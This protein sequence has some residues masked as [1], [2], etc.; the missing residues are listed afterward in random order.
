[1]SDHYLDHYHKTYIPFLSSY[2]KFISKIWKA[3]RSLNVR[4][5]IKLFREFSDDYIDFN[6]W[7][8]NSIN[9]AFY[10]K[11]SKSDNKTRKS[12]MNDWMNGLS[13]KVIRVVDKN[14]SNVMTDQETRS[15]V[16]MK[17]ENHVSYKI[18]KSLM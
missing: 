12:I 5:R 3:T 15:S 16:Q 1:M 7:K 10:S 9:E 11:Y 8:N 2:I 6:Q 13:G 14:Y 4:K 17:F 18:I